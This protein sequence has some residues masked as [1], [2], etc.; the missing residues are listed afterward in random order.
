MHNSDDVQFSL[1]EEPKMEDFEK[2]LAYYFGAK[3][4]EPIIEAYVKALK[5]LEEIGSHSPMH[6]LEQEL[7]PPLEEAYKIISEQKGL[8]FEAHRAAELELKIILGNANGASFET[9]QNFMSQL[10]THVFQSTSRNIRK[11]A[12]LRTFLYQYKVDVQKREKTISDAEMKMLISL[13][14]TSKEFLNTISK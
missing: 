12:M 3:N 7:I 11:A 8:H 2:K 6:I 14:E 9:V 10:Y 13:S 5:K 4:P 1:V